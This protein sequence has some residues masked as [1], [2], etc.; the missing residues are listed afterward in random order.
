MKR[1]I[2]ILLL[3]LCVL[4]A[5]AQIQRNFLGFTLGV[6]TKGQAL[7][8]LRNNN[9]NYESKDDGY[10]IRNVSFAGEKWKIASISFYDNRLVVIGFMGRVSQKTPLANAFKSLVYR[11]NKKYSRYYIDGDLTQ[12]HFSDGTV[13]VEVSISAGFLM[14]SYIYLPLTLDGM[15]L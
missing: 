4:T 9:Y 5:S 13:D 15:D 11:L 10:I 12:Q 2:S 1:T 7:N 3:L 8:Y 14:I 6:T